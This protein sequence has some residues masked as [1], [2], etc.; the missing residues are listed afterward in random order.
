MAEV[1]RKADIAKARVT[2]DERLQHNGAGIAAAVV[3]EDRFRRLAKPGEQLVEPA[4][5]H[6]QHGFLVED[7]DDKAV[8]D[9]LGNDRHERDS[10]PLEGGS[11][12]D[13]WLRRA[14]ARHSFAVL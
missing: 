8:A 11:L 4:Q 12:D 10:A 7:R 3:D 2:L 14:C 1:A 6:W 9:R 5:Q 13:R